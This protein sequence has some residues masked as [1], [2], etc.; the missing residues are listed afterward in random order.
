[1][2]IINIAKDFSPIPGALYEIDGEF[3]G[4]EFR[5]KILILKDFRI[6]SFIRYGNLQ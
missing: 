5:K 6:Q 2:I 3:S 4:E 1:M